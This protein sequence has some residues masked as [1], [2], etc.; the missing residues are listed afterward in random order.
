[1]AFFGAPRHDDETHAH[2]HESPL[3]MLLPL[4]VL[5]VGALVAGYLGYDYFVGEGYG[6]F[7]RTS[8]FAA[9]DNHILE[10]AHHGPEWMSWLPTIMMVGGF[11][12]GLSRLYRLSRDPGLDDPQF[13]ADPRLPLSQMVFRRAV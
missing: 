11:V 5:A 7:W 8:L 2:V 10:A 12:A 13:Q 3:V 4:G 6:G 1:M 9:P